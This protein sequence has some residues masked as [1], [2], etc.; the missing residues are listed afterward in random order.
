M[1]HK[2]LH[3]LFLF[4]LLVGK[5]SAQGIQLEDTDFYRTRIV[6]APESVF[7][8]FTDA[9]M[10][11][12]DHVL[13]DAELKIVDEAF[14]IL[15]PLYKK[16]LKEHL[17]S[18]SFMDNM[19]NTALTSV[20]ETADR[21]RQF[22]IT[23]RAGILNETISQWATWKERSVFDNSKSPGMEIKIDAGD[24]G[25]MLYIL[26]HE[27]THVVD[28]V[29]ELTPHSENADS[30]ELFTSFTKNIWRLP[31]KPVAR[32]SNP[33]LEK[34]RFRG[35]GPQPITAAAGIYDA[36]KKTPFVSL[37]GM[38]AWSEDIAELVTIYHLTH[39]LKQPFVIYLKENN[40]STAVFEPMKNRLVKRRLKQLRVFYE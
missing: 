13:T 14:S 20:L 10:N 32:F 25:A 18:I 36:L 23:F 12:T 40:K 5:S 11:P 35:A 31:N 21:S 27:A 7:K 1:T 4:L 8:K 34:T 16:I 33:L 15:P 37:Y 28:G 39:K 19:P 30:V 29:L 2:I 22:N 24:L 26:L 9:G 17:H 38:A 3:I 6:K